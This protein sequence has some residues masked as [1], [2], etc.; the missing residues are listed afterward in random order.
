MRIFYY[1]LEI[2]INN[3]YILYKIVMDKYDAKVLERVAYRL[4]IIK[5]LISYVIILTLII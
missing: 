4:N 3:S 5:D 2:A 1:C